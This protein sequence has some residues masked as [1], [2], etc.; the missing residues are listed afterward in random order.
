MDNKN[1]KII[2]KKMTDV[3]Y[4]VAD[5]AQRGLSITGIEIKDRKPV[6]TIDS[7]SKA[8][9]GLKGAVVVRITESGRHW[10]TY[11]TE[12]EG[13]QVQWKVAA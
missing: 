11:A 2:A 7:Y 4:C 10:E 3:N 6:V 13:C 9:G 12:V 1:N 5:L 8:P